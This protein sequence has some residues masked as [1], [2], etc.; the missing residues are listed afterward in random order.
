MRPCREI[1][2]IEAWRSETS[3][4]VKD[5]LDD[6]QTTEDPSPVRMTGRARCPAAIIWL[7]RNGA[8]RP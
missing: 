4:I 3:E 5:V 7:R 1:V 6:R 2:G 8:T